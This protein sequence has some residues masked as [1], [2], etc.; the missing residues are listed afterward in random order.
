M[1]EEAKAKRK[2]YLKQYR[3]KNRDKI[4]EYHRNWNRTNPDKV[5]EHTARYWQKK[6]DSGSG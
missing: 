1:T 4:N 3:A 2:E 6:A 5:R